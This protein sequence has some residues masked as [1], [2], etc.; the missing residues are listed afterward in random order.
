M[1]R[2]V[3]FH[4]LRFGICCLLVLIAGLCGFSSAKAQ[5]DSS[6]VYIMADS[7]AVG[8]GQSILSDPF[9]VYGSK[10]YYI[11]IAGERTIVERD[12]LGR[13]ISRKYIFNIPL[14]LPYIMSLQE[15]SSQYRD[16][17]LRENWDTI[18]DEY[19]QEGEDAG[20]I[21]DF[22]FDVPGGRQSTFTT[23]FGK[24]EVNIN[25][26]GTANMNLGA[27]IQ[28]TENPEIPPDQQTQ[29]DPTFEQSLK[30]NIQGTIGDKL[31]IQTDWDTERAFD[32]QNRLNI[33]YQG[34][35]DEIIQSLEIGNV[36]METGNSLI[37]GGSALFGVKSVLQMG[38]LKLTSVL[39]QQD[40]EGQTETITG[41]AQERELSIRPADY[42]FD[43]HYF[44]DFFNF[45]EFEENMSDPQQ[46]GQAFQISEIRVWVLRE[47]TESAD[48][49]RQAISIV[50]LGTVRNQDGTFDLPDE[51]Q[52]P[53]DEATIEEFRDPA[54]SVSAGDFDVDPSEFVEG[55]F[56][57][58]QEGV[59]YELNRLLGYITLKRNLGSRQALAVSFKYTDPQ[60]GETVNVGDVSQSGGNR[61]Y[62]K[63]IRPQTITTTNP[64]WDLMLKNIYSLGANNITPDGL[65][66]D[67]KYTEQNVPSSSLP[68]R[69]PILLQDLGLDRV[70]NQGA[71][72]PDN[73]IDFSTG[74]LDPANG[75]IIFPFLEP[76]G[77]RIKEV[78]AGSGLPESEVDNLA[79]EALY[80]ETKRN[81]NQLAKN[82][83]YLIEGSSKGSVSDNYSLPFGLVEGSVEVFANG[84]RLQ[85]G[86]DFVVDYS[87]GNV[88]ILDDQYLRQGQQIEIE[89]ERNQFAEVLQKTFTGVRAEYEFNRDIRL[90]TTFFRL[91]EDPVQDKIRIGDEPVQNSVIGFDAN[92]RFD[93]PW[94]TRFVDKM[95]L[96]QTNEPSSFSLSGEI[97]QLRPGVSQT[98]A[99]EDAIN[100][101][102]LFEDEENG[103]SFIDD[104]EGV[105]I[106]LS[107]INPTRWNLA[108]APA[109]V[110]GYA[111]DQPF[112]MDNTL[113]NPPA[114]LEDKLARSDLRSQFAWYS[115]PRNIEDILGGVEFTPESEPVKVTDVFP[116]RDVL[117]EENFLTTLDVYY[118]PETRGP[119][120]YNFNLKNLLENETERTWGGMVTTLP[121]GQE[122]LTQNNVEFLEFWVQPV[123]P[124]GQA[125][126]P[127]DIQ[128]YDGTMFIDIGVVSEDVIPNFSTNSED[129]LAR[130]PNDLRR[131]IING[132]ARS[133]IP[134][135][136]PPPEGQFA[137]ERR[138][139]EDVGLD[140]APNQGGVDDK[141]ESVLF[142]DFINAMEASFGSNSSEFEQISNDPSNDDFI[143]YSDN[144]VS[145]LP[146]HERFHRVYGYHE[147]N[148]PA[149]EGE[150]R[151]ITNKPDTEGLITPSIVEQNNSYFQYE[152]DLNPADIDQLSIGSPGT[153][154]VDKVPGSNQQDRWFQV[155]IPL[156]EYV[157][158]VGDIENFQNISYIRVWLSGYEEPFTMRFATFELVGSQWRN[159]E[160][161]EEE[162]NSQ[163]NLNISSV[164]IEEN[165]RRTPIP[166]RQPEGVIRA[167]DRSRQR[168]TIA[169]EQSLLL[170]VENLG[171]QELKMVKRIYPGGLDIINHSNLRMFVHGEGFENRGDAELVLRLGTDL[172]NNF[173]EYR[174]PV[175][176]TDPDFP[177]SDKPLNELSQAEREMEAEQIWLNEENSVNIL[178]R[179]F[180]ELKQLRDQQSNDPSQ[181]FERDN[182]LE[183]VPEGAVIA[184]KGNPSL[185]RIGEIGMGI[186]N[187]FDVSNPEKGVQSLN[188]EFWL[189]ELRVSGF[190]NRKGWAA[191][192]KAELQLADFANINANVSK[193]TDGFGALNSQLGQRRQSDVTAF[194]LSAAINLDKFI[195]DRF[196]WNIPIT[197]STRKSTTT[198][199]FLPNQ[200][201]VR[202]S[203]FKNAVDIREDL[204]EQEKN[205][206]IS[207]RIEE[208]ETFSR[209]YS[210]NASNV[211]KRFSESPWLIYT[212]DK[213]TF[214]FVYNTTD[215]RSP[216]FVFRDN[217]NFNS[218][219]QYSV[220]FRNTRLF[221]PFAFLESVPVLRAASGLK[222]G[223]TPASVNASVGV[224]RDYDERRRR[225]VNGGD[226]VPLQQSHTF[227]YNTNFGFTYNFTPSIRTSFQ[228][229][230]VFDLSRAGIE[231]NGV[232]GTP[233]S[234][235]FRVIPAFKV[236]EGVLTD[237]LSARRSNYEESYSA[238]WQPNLNKIDAFNWVD[239]TANYNGGFQWRNSP[240]GS[241]LGANVSNNL[242]LNQSLNFGIN[243][244]LNRMDWYKELVNP[245][246]N[247]F[248]PSA[249]DS[250]S[251]EG[252]DEDDFGED[253]ANIGKGVLR[254][255][256]SLQA[257][258]VSYNISKNSMQTGFNGGT[259]FFD[260]F[261]QSSNSSSPPFS[262][263]TGIS[264]RIGLD[265]LVDN[266]KENST[267]QLPSNKNFSNDLTLGTRFLPFNNFSVDLTWNTRW[268]QTR[269]RS[270]TIDPDQSRSSVQNR[271]GDISSSVWAFG[272]GY[273]S[274]FRRQLQTAFDD[275]NANN[276]TLSDA[277]GNGDGRTVLGKQ[278]LQEDFRKAYLGAGTGTVGKRGF[279]PFPLPG[280]KINWSGLE[281]V[282]PFL[283]RFMT[284]ATLTHSYNGTYRLGYNFNNDTS[285]F[286]PLNL[287][288]FVVEN[289]R[290][291]FEVNSINVERRFMPLLGFNITWNSNLRTNIQYEFSKLSSL[292]LSNTTV[293]E[294]ISRGLRLSFNYTIRNFKIPLFP[295]IRNAVDF[296]INAGFIEDTE[297]KFVLDSDL[298]DALQD[299]P[300]NI[301]RDPSIFDFSESF[302]G[303]QTRINSSAIIGYQFSQTVKANFEY[304][305]S[306]LNPKSTGV[307]PRTDND[308][309]FNIVVSIRSE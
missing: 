134:V 116:N 79:F 291:E 255:L 181:L 157:R 268:D 104:F 25:V 300:D 252:Y 10:L 219:L 246:D 15:Y 126:T 5:I 129:G 109:A 244:L 298:D 250:A 42:E 99:V 174:Q 150:S 201:D 98:N 299:D 36:S 16:R 59:D 130:R 66:V 241:D 243:Q 193:Q 140:G 47:S 301:V 74:T 173:Y 82:N 210:I 136:L 28:K 107:F 170:Q 7:L 71:V 276:D 4:R 256:L 199:R 97:A 258:D 302:T 208:S 180:N 137:N 96:L 287:G 176:P 167:T 61:I 29:F 26:S 60:T 37:R 85:E 264:D 121:S 171:P 73:R 198:P 183:N 192:A 67:I 50:D 262:F 200:G 237:T 168:R 164:N 257:I 194:D 43:R 149:N 124:G 33:L 245:P 53:F 146:L 128:E 49:E 179:A 182:I 54:V 159:A 238:T 195:P 39:S 58:L 113:R 56:V 142:P 24:P 230:S 13:Y 81:A 111:P 269:T 65:E 69:G 138:A 30:L 294:R 123:L 14:K 177:F 304:T 207:R 307:F 31:F 100:R 271:N 34:Y 274:L 139:L 153:F 222:I 32:F 156:R 68:L 209:S 282:I 306:K 217:W 158:R 55:F 125:P 290:P 83:F 234:T 233:D 309:L 46:L 220:N 102:D 248:S 84:R 122:D 152:V 178:L 305:F 147:G 189:N 297:Q 133:F 19:E 240:F 95:P 260:M 242:S 226:L 160:Q 38:S 23:I 247:D 215:R 225:S 52:D 120:N 86:T 249:E 148:T 27:S 214:N 6:D 191:N 253:L 145:S 221:Q 261:D 62:L 284:R 286:P 265:R 143:F 267:L 92:A 288:S 87:I 101:D 12:S 184:V 21:L 259:Q 279:I 20:N 162:Q 197:L 175:S 216:E 231:E 127:Q 17:A 151:A 283:G 292:A 18:I 275:I 203:D 40:G 285:P 205:R 166:Y 272:N 211:T 141:N 11:D 296:T 3:Y 266:P 1:L 75:R 48:G 144:E 118:D 78:L 35:E 44:L 135:P 218:S 224:D 206:L 228:S 108:A 131:D 119:Y 106:G 273:E 303:G 72:V 235:R 295:R 41:G 117:S 8:L 223:Y 88:T 70:D 63:L 280:W 2:R 204:S 114:T 64:A 186:R 169:N 251:T 161:V 289:S 155:R 165:S 187:P 232:P 115:I 91:K 202:L 22:K 212:L 281:D 57:P 278:S 190:D 163:A 45:Q 112:F 172:V 110:P 270:I 77:S 76:F 263:R 188:A 229:R 51:E 80:D 90:G 132:S 277:T 9:P 254:T 93:T 103:I 94:L 239:Y 89:F 105:D 293:T 227:T 213:T 185:D 196:G 154:I 308:F 236:F